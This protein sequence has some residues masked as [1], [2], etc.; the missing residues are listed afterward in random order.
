VVYLLVNE[1]HRSVYLLFDNVEYFTVWYLSVTVNMGLKESYC[2]L[3][4]DGEGLD[5]RTTDSQIFHIILLK[6]FH[7][8]FLLL[9]VVN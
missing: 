7:D 6:H 3:Y 9:A 8:I 1:L 2:M 4:I 5:E